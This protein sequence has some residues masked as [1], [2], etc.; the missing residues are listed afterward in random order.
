MPK[1]F[2]LLI[3]D[4]L[5]KILREIDAT[6][7]IAAPDTRELY[8]TKNGKIVD[9]VRLKPGEAIIFSEAYVSPEEDVGF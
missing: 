4:A 2:K 1:Q 7:A 9:T 6:G 5:G 8:L 3:L